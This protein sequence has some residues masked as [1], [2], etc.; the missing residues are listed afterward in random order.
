[1]SH[2]EQRE[3]GEPLGRV[4][5][6]R[7]EQPWEQR[8]SQDRLVGAQRVHRFDET[9]ER[10]A[11]LRQLRRRDQRDRDGLGAAEADE[12]VG[13]EPA[14]ALARCEP[15]GL[16][17]HVRQRL[18]D[19]RQADPPRD[20]LDEVDLAFEVG[21]PGRGHGREVGTVA[22]DLDAERDQRV[23]DRFRTE[24]EAEQL[25]DAVGP[26]RDAARSNR[27]RVV[28]DRDGRDDTAR[29]LGEKLAGA[30]SRR[31]DA[32]GIDPP[33]EAVTRLRAQPR[34]LRRAGDAHG[35]EVRGLDE[36]RRGGVG[37]L[38]VTA[39]HDPGEGLRPVVRVA[40]DEIL[41]GEGALDPVERRETLTVGREA[42]ADPAPAEPVEIEGVQRLVAL[43]QHVVRHV[44][45][46][47][48]RP[49]AREGEAPGHPRG[50]LPHRHLGNAGHVP[51]ARGR[52]RRRRPMHLVGAAR[53]ATGRPPTGSGTSNGSEKC[54]ASSRAMP[55]ID[56]AS[57]RLGVI[58]RSNTT[59]SRSSASRT[60]RP[61]SASSGRAR[62]PLW[63]SPRPSSVGEHSMPSDTM[64]RMSLRLE[65]DP[66]RQRGAGRRVRDHHA[67]DDVGRA[68]HHGDLAEAV[69]DVGEP[70]PVGVG[71]WTHVEDPRDDHAP[72]LAA[73]FLDGL[74]LEA[75]VV[76]R[77]GDVVAGRLRSV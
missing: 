22:L 10:E 67:G 41:G 20:L 68:A 54:A 31:R 1:M 55:T 5:L 23:A 47:R 33:F 14:V 65:R 16:A 77:L 26:D 76:E 38:G 25:V 52:E 32:V 48:D 49:H 56:I 46:V 3:I 62:I 45:D 13:D 72:E 61:R 44:D 4:A 69:V 2:L 30:L 9:V 8:W 42:H 60:S 40:D 15:S 75:E 74:D 12:H 43:E 36:H 24:L 11:E 37:H 64:P 59:S 35:V 50:R 39:A 71:M 51:G 7:R 29:D 19:R 27:I 53:D 57:G 6:D 28:V 58:E 73:G 21:P 63:S 34:P 70:G 18:G 17:G 66:A